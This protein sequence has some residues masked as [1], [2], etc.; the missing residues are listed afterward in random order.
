[1][2]PRLG[3]FVRPLLELTRED[4]LA[5]LARR[6]LSWREDPTNRDPAFTR[7]RVRHEI[8]P[9][10]EAA[11]PGARRRLAAAAAAARAEEDLLED[12]TAALLA[13]FVV[14]ETTDAVVLD[15]AWPAAFPAGLRGRA[16]RRLNRRLAGTLAGLERRHADEVVALKRGAVNL[17]GGVR[18]RRGGRGLVFEKVPRSAPVL[19]SWSVRVVVPGV[20]RVPPFPWGVAARVEAAPAAWPA[21]HWWEVWLDPSLRDGLVVRN[22]RPGD[23]VTPTGMT[24]SKKLQDLFVDAKIPRG[25][26]RRWPVVSRGG[27]IVWVPGLALAA[28]AGA[29]G[30]GRP[31]LKL[32]YIG[33]PA[34]TVRRAAAAERT[35]HG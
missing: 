10:L 24:G 34:T 13:P 8:L 17:P 1:M 11:F 28:G 22:W 23:R 29:A 16:V 27:V 4:V 33:P 6:R 15:G 9:A 2:P 12:Q 31:A 30:P 5:Y 26:R 32:T 25:E 19:V 14:S 35:S 7:N 21:A 3:L 20:T 18:V